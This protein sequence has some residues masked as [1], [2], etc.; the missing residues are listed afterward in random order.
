MLNPIRILFWQ[1]NSTVDKSQYI[2]ARLDLL[3]NAL[4]A[5]E[6]NDEQLRRGAQIEQQHRQ[7]L[8]KLVINSRFEQPILAETEAHPPMSGNQQLIARERIDCAYN[9]IRSINPLLPGETLVEHQSSYLS[10]PY[11]GYPTRTGV[12]RM[13]TDL[14]VLYYFFLDCRI[15]ASGDV[16]WVPP[17]DRQQ[18]SLYAQAIDQLSDDPEAQR[19]LKKRQSQGLKTLIPIPYNSLVV[20]P[21]IYPS[22]NS[23][24]DD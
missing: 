3:L 19:C 5:D 7:A 1:F 4:L 20:A 9:T 23:H 17:R 22:S 18:K 11:L 14:A 2:N 10:E 16:T 13:Q 12:I 24:N 6:N 15:E 21:G 8:I